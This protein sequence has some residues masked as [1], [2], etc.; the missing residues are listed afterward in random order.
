MQPP[1]LEQGVWEND[2]VANE[3]KRQIDRGKNP[4]G[5]VGQDVMG[6]RGVEGFLHPRDVAFH[7]GIGFAGVDV[8]SVEQPPRRMHTG[9]IAIFIRAA[10]P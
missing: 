9:R 4:L 5:P 7:A 10:R 8:S 3:G 2:G 1:P 6:R